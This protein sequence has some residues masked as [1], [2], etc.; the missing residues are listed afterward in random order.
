MNERVGPVIEITEMRTAEYVDAD[1]EQ[2]SELHFILEVKGFP[3]PLVLRMK[4][5]EPVDELIEG[6][7][8]HRRS[9]WGEE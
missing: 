8:D 7:K 5:A 2:P 1:Q 4:S 3:Y 6:L 9:I